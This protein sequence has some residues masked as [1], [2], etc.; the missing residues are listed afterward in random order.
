MRAVLSRLAVGGATLLAGAATLLLGPATPAHA[1]TVFIEVNPSTILAGY[2]VALR[3]SCG[4]NPNQAKATSTA[5]G[6]VTMTPEKG[7]L[8]GSATIPSDKKPAGYSVKLT[9][10]SGSTATTTVWVISA[11]STPTKGPNTGGGYLAHHG[12]GGTALLA[13]GLAAV[14]AGGALAFWT[15]RRRREVQL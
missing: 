3:G 12:G 2:Q 6:T 15:A 13:G 14:A 9:C 7:F 4:A 5:F 11:S 1:D 10:A 8:I